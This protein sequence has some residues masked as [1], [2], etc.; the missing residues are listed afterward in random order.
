MV[1]A[2]QVQQ[3]MAHQP[4]QFPLQAVPLFLGLTPGVS[5]ETTMSP[6]S[7]LGPSIQSPASSRAANDN[8]SVGPVFWRQALFRSAMVRH[9]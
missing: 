7:M 4:A 1:P 6:S 9:R 3:A 2:Q 5:R 8:T